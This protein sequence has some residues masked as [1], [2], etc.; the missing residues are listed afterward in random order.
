MKILFDTREETRNITGIGTYVRN[1]AK[2]LRGMDH[3]G[4]SCRCIPDAAAVPKARDGLRSSAVQLANFARNLAWKQAYLPWRALREKADLLVCMDPIGPLASPVPV[5]VLIYDLIFLEGKAQTD[6]WT[7]YWRLMV[8]RCARKA[9]VVFTLSRATQARIV[10]DLGVDAERIVVFRTGVAEHFRPLGLS[11]DE[12][13]RMRRELGLPEVFLLTVGAHDPRRN[14]KTLLRAYG[15]LKR[16]GRF[17]HKLV[18]IG[19]KTPFFREIQQETRS[20]GLEQ[21]VLYLDYVPNEELPAYYNLADAYVYPSFEEGFGLTPLEAM[22]CGCPVVTSRASSL[23]EV[24]GDAAVLVDPANEEELG[25][26]IAEVLSSE[27]LRAELVQKGLE[28]SRRF[29]W[30]AGAEEIVAACVERFGR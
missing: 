7:R 22:A 25:R 12:A 21:D 15:R 11:V 8:P 26:A 13:S 3:P 27:G 30:R 19:P 14:L 17:P 5:G 4:V 2:E 10:A 1:L 6:A 28:R 24:V 23:P 18:V 9:R 16:D 20:R 29:S